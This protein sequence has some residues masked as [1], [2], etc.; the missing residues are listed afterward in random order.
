VLIEQLDFPVLIDLLGLIR[1][2]VV[3]ICR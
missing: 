3:V 2:R 1:R